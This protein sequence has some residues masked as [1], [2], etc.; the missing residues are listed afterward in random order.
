MRNG[1]FV[2]W[3]RQSVLKTVTHFSQFA[4]NLSHSVRHSLKGLARLHVFFIHSSSKMTKLG[5][6]I[7]PLYCL[8]FHFQLPPIPH[9]CRN[10]SSTRCRRANR[11]FAAEMRSTTVSSRWRTSSSRMTIFPSRPSTWRS[12]L[13]GKSPSRCCRSPSSSPKIRFSSVW[14]TSWKLVAILR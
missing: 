9:L 6:E 10:S 14:L 1:S 7:V 13:R 12:R 2:F 3:V 5:I 4:L 8:S 11:A